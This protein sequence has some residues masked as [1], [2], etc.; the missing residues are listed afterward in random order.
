MP[1]APQLVPCV[2]CNEQCP[3]IYYNGAGPY[4]HKHY[5]KAKEADQVNPPR[6]K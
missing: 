1:D 5:K 3:P 6:E 4:C 2:I